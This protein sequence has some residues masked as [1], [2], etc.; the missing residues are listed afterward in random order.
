MQSDVVR[1]RGRS[2]EP[3][4]AFVRCGMEFVCCSAKRIRQIESRF[5]KVTRP[6]VS[7][8]RDRSRRFTSFAQESACFQTSKSN[9][10]KR[11]GI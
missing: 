8:R 9:D 4:L 3:D 7:V 2:T 6:L 11:K 1:F 10:S 5:R